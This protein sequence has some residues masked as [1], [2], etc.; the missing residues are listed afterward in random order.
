MTDGRVT[1]GRVAVKGQKFANGAARRFGAACAALSVVS[2]QN[3]GQNT[4]HETR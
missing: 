2:V 4:Q 3:M 1:R